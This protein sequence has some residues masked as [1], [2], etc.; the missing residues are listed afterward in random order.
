[1][2]LARLKRELLADPRVESVEAEATRE[3][4][5]VP[6]DPA[7]SNSDS[8]AP[9]GDVFQW[10]LLRSNFPSAWDQSSGSGASVAIVDT[11]TEGSHPDLGQVAAAVD[12]DPTAPTGALSD[13]NGHGTHVSGLACGNSN[14][15]YGIASAGFDCPLIVEKLEVNGNTLTDASIIAGIVD[16][17]NQ[18]ADVINLSLGGAAPSTTLSDA[19][20]YAF[21]NDVV[22]VAAASN[23]NTS[24]QG[25]PAQYLQPTG[26]APDINQGKGLVV[27]AAEYD[28][29]RADLRPVNPGAGFGT[30]VSIAAYGD[31]S[32]STS[33]IFSSFPA[34][35]TTR[36]P[37]VCPTPSCAPR[38]SFFGDDQFAYLF[39]TSMATPQVWGAAALIR[40]LDPGIANTEVIRALKQGARPGSFSSER[41]G[42]SSTSPVR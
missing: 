13:E 19:I 33:G 6:N 23:N 29:T 40:S 26:T 34:D 1:L 42:G 3:L 7:L 27:T 25:Y 5:L 2:P 21:A 12:H 20:D 9:G 31:S 39:G 8:N 38:T 18:G 24:S 11:G 28:D 22:L 37:A 36:E 14:N 30:G 10:N 35:Q 16:A 4:L 32:V 41:A 15:G 17:T